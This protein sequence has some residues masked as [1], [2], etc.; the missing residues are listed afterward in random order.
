MV[1]EDEGDALCLCLDEEADDGRESL[2]LF[3]SLELL[4]DE[5]MALNMM[6]AA[7]SRRGVGK[8]G[9]VTGRNV[10][11]GGEVERWE[12]RQEAQTLTV[13]SNSTSIQPSGK[14]IWLGCNA[15]HR[16]TRIDARHESSAA[17]RR[18]ANAQG[19]EKIVR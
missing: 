6:A 4:D 7:S 8:Y 13:R 3:C 9:G 15:C 1:G 10:S 11:G 18:C 17:T 14:L 16:N 12:R 5:K 2:L 19:K